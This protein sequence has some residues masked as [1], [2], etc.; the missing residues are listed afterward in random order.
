ML[1]SLLLYLSFVSL[2]YINLM[3]VFKKKPHSVSDPMPGDALKQIQKHVVKNTNSSSLSSGQQEASTP[4][5]CL[6]RYEKATN[7]YIPLGTYADERV[8]GQRPSSSSS[9][10][11]KSK[12]NALKK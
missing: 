5:E 10:S 1:I 12:N 2:L 4:Q 3:T 9:S 8:G 7:P 11:S 6:A